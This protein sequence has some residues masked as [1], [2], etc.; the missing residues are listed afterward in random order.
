MPISIQEQYESYIIN[1]VRGG[2]FSESRNIVNK[3]KLL[4]N[5]TSFLHA[6]TGH[7]SLLNL[8]KLLER[9]FIDVSVYFLKTKTH[10]ILRLLVIE[11][12]GANFNRYA[13]KWF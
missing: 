7:N 6:L 2:R 12:L 9:R 11:I 1:K 8:Q 3:E 4:R 10:S 5:S 13:S